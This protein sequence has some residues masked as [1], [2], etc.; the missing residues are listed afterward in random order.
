MTFKNNL[1]TKQQRDLLEVLKQTQIFRENWKGYSASKKVK[2]K[3]VWDERI[4]AEKKSQNEKE[5]TWDVEYNTE[6][7]HSDFK[8]CPETETDILNLLPKQPKYRDRELGKLGALWDKFKWAKHGQ[9]LNVSCTSTYLLQVF[10]NH[11]QASR[12][13]ILSDK[14][15]LT[16]TVDE[17]Y[18]FGAEKKEWNYSKKKAFNHHVG[19]MI[20][21]LCSKFNI[22]PSTNKHRKRASVVQNI[23]DNLEVKLNNLTDDQKKHLLNT[24]NI[25]FSAGMR[26]PGLTE[27][28]ALELL[29][30]KYP[31]IR[32]TQK[33]IEMI[34]N[35]F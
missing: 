35:T 23:D 32:D 33:I 4:K 28:T 13:L 21:Q 9:I 31:Q 19:K 10:K 24:Y 2:A 25:G 8:G 22:N 3:T 15:G 20:D 16:I 18:R 5:D 27:K 34:T 1:N 6:V 29:H 30:L 14:V 12:V 17:K 11:V 7:L 26:V